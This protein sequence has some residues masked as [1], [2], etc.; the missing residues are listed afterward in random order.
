MLNDRLRDQQIPVEMADLVPQVAE[1]GTIGFAQRDLPRFA[2]RVVGFDEV[3][4]D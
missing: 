3:E 4:R 1:Q 2:L